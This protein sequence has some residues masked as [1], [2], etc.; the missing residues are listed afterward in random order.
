MTTVCQLE[1][2]IQVLY[3]DLSQHILADVKGKKI[4][5]IKRKNKK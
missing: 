3:M 1:S 5:N 2:I 4:Y